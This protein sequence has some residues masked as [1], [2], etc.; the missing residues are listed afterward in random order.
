MTLTLTLV[1]HG[2]THFNSRQILQGSS[3]SPL[4]RTGREG[5]R[6]TARHLA[7]SDFVAAYTSPAGRAVTTAVEII[8]HHPGLPLTVE[9]GL[10][11][12]DFG[13]FERRPERELEAFEPWAA[14]VPAVLAGRHP[15]L[16]DGEPGAAYMARVT[17]T[18]DRIVAAHDAAAGSGQGVEVLVVGHGLTLG[19][20]L[21][22]L[23]RG[24][25]P[26]LPNASV[27]TVRVTDGVPEVVEVGLDIAGH[28]LRAARP[29]PAPIPA[30]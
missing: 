23:Q 8:R 30:P 27:S 12:Y 25:L 10:R 19:A 9:T 20:Y 11:E 22:T 5:V 1:R 15:G 7:A 13:K 6:T 4:T 26:A 29:A 14:L 17:A 21:W 2:Q 3:N 16:P 28:G 18:F 24:G